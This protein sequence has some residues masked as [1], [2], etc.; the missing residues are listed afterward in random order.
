MA[1]I[2]PSTTRI[3]AGSGQRDGHAKKQPRSAEETNR[4]GGSRRPTAANPKTAA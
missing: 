2:T 3:T 4:A 1:F